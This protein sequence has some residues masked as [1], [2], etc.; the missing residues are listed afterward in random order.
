MNGKLNLILL[1]WVRTSYSSHLST[2]NVKELQGSI[3]WYEILLEQ[4]IFNAL[5]LFQ[6]VVVVNHF[7]LCFKK[8]LFK[9]RFVMDRLGF[10]AKIHY[11]KSSKTP[12][13]DWILFFFSPLISAF[14]WCIMTWTVLLANLITQYMLEIIVD[15]F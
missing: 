14:K 1:K 11:R 2:D 13:L 5:F 3:E 10:Y 7:F 12:F 8:S 9:K 6:I 15:K 4:M